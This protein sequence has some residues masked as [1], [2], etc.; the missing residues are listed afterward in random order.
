MQPGQGGEGP[1]TGSRGLT[2]RPSPRDRR[3]RFPSEQMETSEKCEATNPLHPSCVG[4][5]R[6][7]TVVNSSRQLPGCFVKRIQNNKNQSS[8][9]LPKSE[10]SVQSDWEAGAR[11][12]GSAAACPSCSRPSHGSGSG[13]YQNTPFPGLWAGQWTGEGDVGAS[14]RG[15]A[16]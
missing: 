10:A 6:R 9:F 8:A 11:A 7:Q 5:F 1:A 2:R 4:L 13:L 3:P 15:E 12:E 14:G 16:G